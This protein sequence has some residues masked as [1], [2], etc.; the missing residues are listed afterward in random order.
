MRRC[1]VTLRVGTLKINGGTR[2]LIGIV[3]VG[4]GA[5]GDI[6]NNSLELRRF[7]SAI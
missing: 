5:L 1:V 7:A 2:G 3:R 6:A 4:M